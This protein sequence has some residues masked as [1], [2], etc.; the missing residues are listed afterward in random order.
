[1]RNKIHN[2]P[3]LV[4]SSSKHEHA[5]ELRV[6]HRMID[7]N[8]EIAELIYL[9]L[10]RGLANPKMGRLGRMT[11]EQVFKA[12]I[13]KQVNGF[14]FDS[15]AFHLEDSRAYRA[16]C[17]FGIGDKLPSK[18]ALNRDFKKIRPETLEKINHVILGAAK[19]EGIEKGRKVRVDCTVVESNIHHPTDS[20]LLWDCVR[21]LSGFTLRAQ[22]KFG[23]PAFDRRRR[24]KKRAMQILN[25]KNKAAR[26]K[27]YRDLLKV[28]REVVDNAGQVAAKLETC[29]EDNFDAI[30]IANELRHYMPLAERVMFQTKIRILD[31]EK[32][33]S[34]EKLVSIFE[35]HTDI[36]IKDRRDV[37]YGH[38]IV[39]TSTASGLFSDLVIEKGNPADSQLA[40]K[41]IERQIDIYGR[42]PRQAAYDGG[43]A[44][45]DNL[46]NIQDL[47][48]SDAVFA[49]KR[50]LE[51]VDMAK[52][53]W[54]YKQLRNFRAGVEGM[55]SF[56]KRGFGL[57][58]CTWS[59]FESF[60]AYA[61]SSVLSA[62]LL[63][64]AR[65]RMAS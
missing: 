26:V 55:I 38:K 59:G 2:Q 60:K 43:F 46:K 56:L 23:V 44:S 47:G 22:E 42:S 53:V 15:L 40:V 10:V 29:F 36:I 51:I 5:Q 27:P 35:P 9:D 32:L 49:K 25:A 61:W 63:L 16:F 21:V 12:I 1:M 18:S 24:A 41:M 28:T 37:L 39:V 13:I 17:G 34:K 48:V 65:R 20:S 8:P 50:G 62:N 57:T 30:A 64:M 7:E 33:P 52:S 19:A 4:E 3:G 11:A 45:K 54:V 58:R 14:T 31:K 6:I